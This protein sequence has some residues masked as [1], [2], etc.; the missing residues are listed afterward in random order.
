M[1]PGAGRAEQNES[2]GEEYDAEN[3]HTPRNNDKSRMTKRFSPHQL[4]SSVYESRHDAQL[5]CSLGSGDLQVAD[6]Y[7]RA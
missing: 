5:N 1:G 7:Q 4:Q 2:E 6:Q 3:A